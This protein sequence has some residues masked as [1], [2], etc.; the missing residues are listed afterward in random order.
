MNRTTKKEPT[1][2]RTTITN[3]KG[4]S[5]FQASFTFPMRL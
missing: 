5:S 2:P 1:L 3:E 4:S